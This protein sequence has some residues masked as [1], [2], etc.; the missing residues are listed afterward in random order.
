MYY[1]DGIGDDDDDD[2]GTEATPSTTTTT[3]TDG[4]LP[5]GS[6]SSSTTSTSTTGSDDG[7]ISLDDTL[8]CGE[9]VTGY[10]A[11]ETILDFAF[12]NMVS[13]QVTFTNCES[14][15]DTKM[16]LIDS[17]GAFIQSQSTNSCDGDDCYESGDNYCSTPYRETFTMDPLSVGTTHGPWSN[18]HRVGAHREWIHRK[19]LSIWGTTVI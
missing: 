17:S 12:V 14:E 9:T 7:T 19:C 10:L 6:T 5:G 1:G 16:Y 3:T 11:D 4:N 13:Q 18:P 8:S 2:D 15:F